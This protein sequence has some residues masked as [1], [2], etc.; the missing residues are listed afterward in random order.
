[1]AQRADPIKRVHE[2]TE[3]VEALFVRAKYL[4]KQLK[5]IERVMHEKKR[6][7]VRYKY[8]RDFPDELVLCKRCGNKKP[9]NTMIVQYL[10]L[11]KS[12][13]TSVCNECLAIQDRIRKFNKSPRAFYCPHCN[14]QTDDKRKTMCYLCSRSL[15]KR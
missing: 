7:L 4:R 8:V 15:I 3:E 14:W 11:T 9:A 1:M 2:L 13:I 5:P 6:L 12:P 10:A